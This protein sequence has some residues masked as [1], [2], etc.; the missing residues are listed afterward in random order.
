VAQP[1]P[2]I[3][4]FISYCQHDEPLLRQLVAHLANL[5]RTLEVTGALLAHFDAA[6]DAR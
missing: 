1:D 5:E 3:G 4:V 6:G 2:P